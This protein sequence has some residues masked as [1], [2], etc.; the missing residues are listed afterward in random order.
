MGSSDED[1][2]SIDSID[3][4]QPKEERELEKSVNELSKYG[5][6]KFT[7]FTWL[8]DMFHYVYEKLRFKNI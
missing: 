1:Y 2:G 6:Y 3:I 7:F 5:L 4:Y 8:I